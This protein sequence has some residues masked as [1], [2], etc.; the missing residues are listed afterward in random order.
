MKI[1][2]SAKGDAFDK[3]YSAKGDVFNRSKGDVFNAMGDVFNAKGM[4]S[5]ANPLFGMTE[6]EV[7]EYYRNDGKPI[8][9][10]DNYY[11]WLDYDPSAV[12][13]REDSGGFFDWAFK[14]VRLADETTDVI[15]KFRD[16]ADA[17]TDA[18][19]YEI[20]GGSPIQQKNNT[21]WIVV[22]ASVLALTI[23]LIVASKR[24]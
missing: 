8:P 1:T 18:V 19:D 3:M 10:D 23:A 15:Q 14:T 22:G 2:K 13:E 6:E 11:E 16:G 20:R 5:R 17:E 4:Y 21:I 24:K 12:N 9:F 7:Y